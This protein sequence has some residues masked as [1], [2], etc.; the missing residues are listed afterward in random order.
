M[1]MEAT[2]VYWRPVWTILEGPFEL[3]LVNPSHI[4]A[5]PG[6]KT[7]IKDCEWI[8]DLLQHGLRHDHLNHANLMVLRNELKR[9]I[10]VEPDEV[11]PD[12]VTMHSTVSIVDLQNEEVSQFTLVFPEELDSVYEGVSVVAPLGAAVLGYKEKDIIR[13]HTPG[14]QRRIKIER[15]LFQPEAV[16]RLQLQAA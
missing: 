16:E 14:G 3:L 11:E 15:L 1:A 4:K 7:D 9:A 10:I 8:A 2:G 6:R 12:V 13:F 5:L